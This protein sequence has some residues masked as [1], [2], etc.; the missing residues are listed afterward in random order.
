MWSLVTLERKTVGES[1]ACPTYTCDYKNQQD[2]L[3]TFLTDK[4]EAAC[5]V[6]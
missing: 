5:Q 6:L 2:E 4:A 1:H 3:G